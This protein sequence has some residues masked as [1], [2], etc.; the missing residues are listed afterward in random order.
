MA[1]AISG[2]PAGLS[3]AG[4]SSADEPHPTPM[5]TLA[6]PLRRT[7]RL[8]RRQ[9]PGRSRYSSVPGSVAIRS[10]D[11]LTLAS[12]Q[13]QS[14]VGSRKLKTE[15][16]LPSAF[17]CCLLANGVQLGR[18]HGRGGSS[19]VRSCFSGGGLVG[20]G[21]TLGWCLGDL[22]SSPYYLRQPRA[23]LVLSPD[24]PPGRRRVV[25]HRSCEVS[26]HD[27]RPIEAAGCRGYGPGHPQRT[28]GPVTGGCPR[29]GWPR[30]LPLGVGSPAV[31]WL[32]VS[33]I[34]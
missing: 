22:A 31:P 28:R 21:R 34:G 29:W 27:R 33:Q 30:R 20:V 4:V 13:R 32:S 3:R 23:D 16:L 11:G 19:G 2:D 26:G 6:A 8:C 5:R 1:K 25:D 18:A 17:C 24:P 15:F 14:A 10:C 12:R 7:R 9:C